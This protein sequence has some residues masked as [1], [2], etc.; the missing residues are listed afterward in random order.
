M[1]G[2]RRVYAV[3]AGPIIELARAVCRHNGF[4]DRIIFLN[5]W[6]TNVELPEPV[7]VIVTET[8][9][10]VG[11]EE[12]ILGWILDAKERLLAEG[13]KIVPRSVEL[14]VAPVEDATDYGYVD[15]WTQDLHSLDFSPARALAVNN[16]L[17]AELS[18]QSCLGEPVPLVCVDTAD[19]ASADIGGEAS[20]VA[21]RDGLVHGIGA[22]FAAEL[23]PG[24]RISNGPPLRTPSWSQ[25]LLPLE[26][27]LRVREG[28]RLW[29][30]IQTRHHAAHWQWQV[31]RGSADG[32]MGDGATNEQGTFGEA[33]RTHQ[34]TLSGE[35]RAPDPMFTLGHMPR[36]TEE[37]EV[38]LF[39]LDAMDGVTMVEEIAR[40]TTARFPTQFSTTASALEHIYDLTE[41]YCRWENADSAQSTGRGT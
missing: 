18:A 16:M 23:A 15:S 17:W 20:F 26:R 14:V 35:L 36:R 30:Q 10:N 8:I 32:G 13:G 25:V 37:A 33:I 27:P 5:D 7:D 21:T 6:S 22:W 11:F 2:A 31:G 1:S 4:E 38:D 12:G 19:A 3:E 34:E 28:D 41:A 39:I 40:Q 9:G 24:E 29:V